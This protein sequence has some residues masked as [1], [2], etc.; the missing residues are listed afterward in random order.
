MKHSP[1]VLLLFRA[2]VLCL[3]GQR[4]CGLCTCQKDG[5]GGRIR[6]QARWERMSDILRLSFRESL[7]AHINYILH[8]L[9]VIRAKFWAFIWLIP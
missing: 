2:C 9:S 5:E 3:Q 6:D 8:H 1:S 4:A 7:F